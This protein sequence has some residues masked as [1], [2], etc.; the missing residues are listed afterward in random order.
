MNATRIARF[1]FFAIGIVLL[2]AALSLVLYNLNEDQKS[3]EQA[4]NLLAEVKREIPDETQ[5]TEAKKYDLFSEY[6]TEPAIEEPI[7]EIDGQT[8]IGVI[9]IPELGIELPVISEWSYPNLKS[10]PCRYQGTA[11]DRDMILIAHNYQTHF[12]R[13]SELHSGSEIVF[14][15]AAGKIYAYEVNNIENIVGTDIESME[16]GSADSWDLTLFTC[17]ISGQ[18]RVTVRAFL[19][20]EEEN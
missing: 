15:D 16:F 17:T 6:E 9:A 10:A 19:K 13:I 5:P 2:G 12:G 20:P 18:S 8:Y 7:L 14:T 4:Q 11:F 3:G 1:G